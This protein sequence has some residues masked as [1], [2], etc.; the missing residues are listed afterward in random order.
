MVRALPPVLRGVLSLEGLNVVEMFGSRGGVAGG[1]PAVS[2]VG[3]VMKPP[4][5]ATG[6]LEV[7]AP[8][9]FMR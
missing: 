4:P 5:K 1:S 8:S 7:K 6:M 3:S 2:A 9:V